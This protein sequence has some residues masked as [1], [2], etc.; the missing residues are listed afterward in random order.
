VSVTSSLKADFYITPEFR[1]FIESL[2]DL[3][4]E[5]KR[6]GK[7]NTNAISY[8]R[9]RKNVDNLEES[10]RL[11]YLEWD[12]MNQML[13]TA[14]ER[15]LTDK[16]RT[17]LQFISEANDSQLYTN[18]IDRLSVEMGVPHSTVRWNLKG[19]REAGLIHAG[20]RDNKG[21]PVRLTAKGR[22][23]TR[24]VS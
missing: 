24:L 13:Q 12:A 1:N 2:N 5:I 15:K 8:N 20:D 10:L 11:H 16:Q 9:L 22:I 3:K 14:S 17:I 7:T 4:T 23:M 6:F 21:I 19:L 18:L